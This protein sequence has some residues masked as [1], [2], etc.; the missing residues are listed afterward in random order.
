MVNKTWW[1]C[2]GHKKM[3]MDLVLAGITEK[4]PF[5]RSAEKWVLG[6]KC[7]FPAFPTTLPGRGRNM[8][9]PKKWVIFFGPE[10]SIFGPKIR[11]CFTTPTFDNGLFVALGQ[12]DHFAPW[13]RFFDFSFPSYSLFVKRKSQS[14]HQKVFPHPPVRAPS[15]SNSPSALS[16]RA[17]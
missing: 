11:F 4:R 17:G 8:V 9:S 15:A 6:Q 7:V 14:T 10:N 3:T 2:A 16:A 12:T 1:D 5:L 13:D